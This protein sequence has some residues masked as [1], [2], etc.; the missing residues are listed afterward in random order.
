MPN[1]PHFNILLWE[2]KGSI[3]LR[4]VN[5][6]NKVPTEEDLGAC[7]VNH[8]TGEFKVDPIYRVKNERLDYKP[9]Q[10]Y[11]SV[12]LRHYLKKLVGVLS[13]TTKN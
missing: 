2:I 10:V 12:Y 6:V 9:S 3:L 11:H 8:W 4:P 7:K 5:F 1:T 13:L